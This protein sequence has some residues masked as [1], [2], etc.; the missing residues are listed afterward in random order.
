MGA[1]W[2]HYEDVNGV[3]LHA[4][5]LIDGISLASELN[6]KMRTCKLKEQK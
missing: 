6:S 5:G 2:K 4:R 3:L 1:T